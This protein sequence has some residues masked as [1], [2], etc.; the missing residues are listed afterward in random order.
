MIVTDNTSKQNPLYLFS[1]SLSEWFIL[2]YSECKK[3]QLLMD[4]D[5][6]APIVFGQLKFPI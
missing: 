6:R 1:S 4:D 2:S 3:D 5:E